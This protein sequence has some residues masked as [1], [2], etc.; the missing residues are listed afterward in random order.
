MVLKIIAAVSV[1]FARMFFGKGMGGMGGG[2]LA[3]IGVDTGATGAGAWRDS[4][5]L[6][7][8]GGSNS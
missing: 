2:K 5:E 8:F 6:R 1:H 7:G 4:I 3:V